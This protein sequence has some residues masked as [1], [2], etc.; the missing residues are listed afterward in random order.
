MFRSGH[1][2]TSASSAKSPRYFRLQADITIWVLRSVCFFTACPNQVPLFLA[3]PLEVHEMTWKCLPR[4]SKGLLSSTK[5]SLNSCRESGNSCNRSLVLLRILHL[6]FCFR[7]L[8]FYVAGFPVAPHS[9][10]HVFFL[11]RDFPCTC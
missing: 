5:I 11:L 1:D 9:Y 3:T 2:C 10:F 7:S 6:Y 8:L 4:G